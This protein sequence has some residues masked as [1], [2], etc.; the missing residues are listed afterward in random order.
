MSIEFG[1]STAEHRG[2]VAW[3]RGGSAG[4]ISGTISVA[5][6]GWASGG[7][8][9]DSTTLVLLAAAAAVIGALVAG[10]APLRDTSV[11]LITALVAGQLL[12][13][14]TMGFNS[15]HLHHGD[16]QL[17]PTMLTAHVLAAMAAA[18]L[19]RG[20]ETAY[21]TGTAV[22][23]RVLRSPR[24]AP[25]LADPAPLRTTHRDRVILRVLA[26]A[27]LRTRGPP[28]TVS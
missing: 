22:L 5:A 19:I 6:H 16:A 4:A 24:S 11:G 10:L 7:M 27:S 1:R 2:A 15:G 8:P 28:L 9:P 25:V 13:H 12:G 17:T 26:A 20:A 3:V 14:F 21:R 18:L 23:F